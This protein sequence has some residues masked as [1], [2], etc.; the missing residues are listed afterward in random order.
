MDF[1]SISTLIFD[2]GGVLI[3]LKREAAIDAFRELGLDT[4]DQ[5]LDNYVQSGIFMQLENGSLSAADFRDEVR[6]LTA[7]TVTDEQIDQA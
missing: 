3:N 6:K 1:T 5:L 4:A 2:F 7:S